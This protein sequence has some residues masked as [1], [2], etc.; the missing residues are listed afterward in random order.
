MDRPEDDFLISEEMAEWLGQKKSEYLSNLIQ[1]MAADD[2]GFE[3]FQRFDR[4]LTGTIEDPDR[5][6]G[7]EEDGQELRTYVKTYHQGEKVHQ[8]L[9]GVL[10]PDKAK[11]AQVL[12]PIISFV[13][14]KDDLVKLFTKGKVITRPTLN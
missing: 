6:Y 13:S 10:L 8:V 7:F 1:Q 3:E 14:R 4:L 12:V 11:D 9:I 5:A 2:F